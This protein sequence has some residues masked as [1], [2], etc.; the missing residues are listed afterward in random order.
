MMRER[1]FGFYMCMQESKYV[2]V[3]SD[4][5]SAKNKSANRSVGKVFLMI[6]IGL[7]FMVSLVYSL[8]KLWCH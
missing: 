5:I 3:F 8:I 6:K 2:F 1:S 4:L 7:R